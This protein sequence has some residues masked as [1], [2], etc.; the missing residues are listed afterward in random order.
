MQTRARSGSD[1]GVPIVP[2][3]PGHPD[4][5]TQVNELFVPADPYFI[6]AMGK[7][8][9]FTGSG[10]THADVMRWLFLIT[11]FAGLVCITDD[12]MVKLAITY[13]GGAALNWAMKR[14][15]PTFHIFKTGLIDAF[16]PFNHTIIARDQL[17]AITQTT[18]VLAYTNAFREAAMLIDDM[19]PEELLDR[20]QDGLK[21]DIRFQLRMYLPSTFDEAASLACRIDPY[22]S[23]ASTYTPPNPPP[24]H[25]PRPP[26]L[27]SMLQP[28]PRPLPT[29]ALQ[30]PMPPSPS[31]NVTTCLPTVAAPIA[32]SSA[33]PSTPAPAPPV[34]Q[35]AP[36]PSSHRWLIS[37]GL[38][39]PCRPGAF[40]EPWSPSSV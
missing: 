6:K 20:Y 10:V 36:G 37:D 29:L 25:N 21:R 33:T 15:F 18:S 19:S 24:P 7:P 14:S 30:V 32:V 9:V 4:L 35:K 17:K 38:H 12:A 2:A 1:S 11:N 23:K 39:G 3:P 22:L 34:A 31:P 40:V 26:P 13:L 16:A 8:P 28:P 27:V 5:T